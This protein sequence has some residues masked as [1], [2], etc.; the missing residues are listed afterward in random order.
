[1]RGER[2]IDERKNPCVL[3]QTRLAHF[4]P[5]TPFV[6]PAVSTGTRRISNEDF[7]SSPQ[8]NIQLLVTGCIPTEIREGDGGSLTFTR[9][10]QILSVRYAKFPKIAIGK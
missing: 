5:M 4:H 1:M 7:H 6:L 2:L 8:R 9:K 3:P 10:T